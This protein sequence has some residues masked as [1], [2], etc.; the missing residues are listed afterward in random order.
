MEL[1]YKI[2]PAALWRKA[3]DRGRF[4]GAEID[5][6]DGFIHFSSATQVEETARR[7]FS[8][9][10]DLLLIAVD[11]K[12][13]GEA[14]RFEGSRNGEPF[15]HLYGPLPLDAIVSVKRLPSTAQ[16]GHDFSGLIER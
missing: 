12:K 5:R 11:A 13:L 8:G 16:G 1:I 2:V 9:Q 10:R 3:Q 7:H 15:P 4:E 14:L 6:K